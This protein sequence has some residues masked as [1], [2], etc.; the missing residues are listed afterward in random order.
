MTEFTFEKLKVVHLYIEDGG[1]EKF[2]RAAIDE[3]HPGFL[4]YY[5]GCKRLNK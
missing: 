3:L 1:D 2:A 4:K 5:E